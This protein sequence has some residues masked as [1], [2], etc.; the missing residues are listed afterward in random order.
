[1]A[2]PKNTIDIEDLPAPVLSVLRKSI[3]ER[4]YPL[5]KQTSNAY[6]WLYLLGIVALGWGLF[7]GFGVPR[8]AAQDSGSLVF[9]IGGVGLIAWGVISQRKRK[10]LRALLGFTP[11]VYVLGSRLVDARTRTLGVHVLLDLK[12]DIVH[13]Y[14]NGGYRN[15]TITWHGHTF[16]FGRK[17]AAT[18]ALDAIGERFGELQKA[19]E[20]NEY[21]QLLVLDPL[22]I[23]LA[24]AETEKEAAFKR[25]DK[26]REK[27]KASWTGPLVALAV[28]GVVAPGAWYLR[29]YLSLESAYDNIH[30][31]YDVDEWVEHGG[32]EARGHK[33]RMEIEL[34]DVLRYNSENANNLRDVLAKYPDAPAALKKPVEDALHA[35]YEKARK[36]ALALSASEQLTWYI[37]TVYDRLDKGGVASMQV[38]VARTD[39]TELAKLDEVV[40]A[41][42]KLSKTIVPVAKYFGTSDDESRTTRLKTAIQTGLGEFFPS[43]VM[44]FADAAQ[45]AKDAAVIEIFYVISPKY[46]RD[47]VPSLYSEVDKFNKPIPGAMSYPGIMFELGAT[48]QVPGGPPAQKVMF[49]ATPSPHINVQG[50]GDEGLDNGAVYQAMAESAFAD[51]ERK[52]VGALGGKAPPES[53]DDSEGKA[54]DASLDNACPGLEDAIQTFTA[55]T[56]ITDTERERVLDALKDSSSSGDASA[57][58]RKVIAL[59][60]KSIKANHCTAAPAPDDT[61]AP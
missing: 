41:N 34:T 35:R 47:G 24:M 16:V 26:I 13:R 56:K 49:Q 4:W 44:T 38:K 17:D 7:D 58:C 48:L 31:T 6:I 15:T 61:P 23:G 45:D 50:Y 42:P 2:A 20:A 3:T 57:A 5:G 54:D 30:S 32:D 27:P 51:L 60:Q 18:S 46:S 25:G 9:Y 55:C 14:V 40:A 22:V 36:A 59:L 29:N 11:G 52:L 28:T 1:M 53:A 19:F 8:S 21:D 39:N 10:A 37:N 12:P 43:D 33:K